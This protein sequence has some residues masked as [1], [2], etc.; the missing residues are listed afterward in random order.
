MSQC[1]FCEI[2]LPSSQGSR[3]EV[4]ESRVKR[5]RPRVKVFKVSFPK[6]AVTMS[7]VRFSIISGVKG[8]EM[9]YGFMFILDYH[10]VIFFD[11]IDQI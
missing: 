6:F 5:G 8:G 7:A 2:G 4:R 9:C 11:A 3:V 10:I 1:E